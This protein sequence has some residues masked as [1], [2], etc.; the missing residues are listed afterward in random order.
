MKRI[1][2]LYIYPCMSIYLYT[3]LHNITL[4]QHQYIDYATFPYWSSKTVV[5]DERTHIESYIQTQAR[6]YRHSATIP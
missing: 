5:F 6:I 2:S 1:S 4:Y 3:P